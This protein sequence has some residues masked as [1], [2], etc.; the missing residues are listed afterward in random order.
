MLYSR[1]EAISEQLR[2]RNLHGLPFF[3]PAERDYKY[4]DVLDTQTEHARVTGEMAYSCMQVGNPV[5]VEKIANTV[6]RV[7]KL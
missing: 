2:A 5:F 6:M 3:D 7:E 4:T 1:K